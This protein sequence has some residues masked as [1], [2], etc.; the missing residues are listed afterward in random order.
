MLPSIATASPA[1]NLP[2]AH[3]A[4]IRGAAEV[5]SHAMTEAAPS[6]PAIQPAELLAEQVRLLYRV[7]WQTIWSNNLGALFVA[8]VCWPTV[9][10]AGVLGWLAAI[11]ANGAARFVSF[12]LYRRAGGATADTARRW[13][14]LYAA[15]SLIVGLSWGIGLALLLQQVTG[16]QEVVLLLIA[17]GTVAGGVAT[18]VFL[19]AHAAYNIGI[20][21]P[22]AVGFLVRDQGW[23]WLL[24]LCVLAFVVLALGMA[25]TVG[26]SIAR[27]LRLGLENAALVKVL[28]QAREEAENANQARNQF[29]A[30]MGHEF[31]TPLN[32]ILGFSQLMRDGMPSAEAAAHWQAFAGDIHASG[33]R[34]LEIINDVLDMA[35]L[36]SG[37]YV[38][39]DTKVDLGETLQGCLAAVREPATAGGVTLDVAVPAALPT[40]RADP[41]AVRQVL[42]NLLTNAVKF[43]GS[44]GLVSI[45]AGVEPDGG[46]ALSVR[47]TGIGIDAEHQTLVF[48]PFRQVEMGINRTYEGTGLGL[49]ISKLLM[50]LHEGSITLE[51]ALGQGTCVTVRFPAGRVLAE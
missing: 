47:D 36:E 2:D 45:D 10:L 23:D 41:R 22:L 20:M 31:R 38:L 37:R 3:C 21:T 42:L 4:V 13:G 29:L 28:A 1:E 43:T 39:K 32:A 15:L 49:P 46:V 35:R 6:A 30:N 44:G 26:G 24:A 16:P 40:L 8:A 12:R 7:G 34:L 50:E 5:G 25:R 14:L 27:G 51:S 48:E 11:L 9:P 19:P 17:V 18:G 33:E